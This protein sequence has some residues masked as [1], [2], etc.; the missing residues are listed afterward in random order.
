MTNT[1]IALPELGEKVADADFI[2]QTLQLREKF[3]KRVS[4]SELVA[5]GRPLAPD[6]FLGRSKG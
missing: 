1:T 5:A 4:I 2:K 3:A 6:D